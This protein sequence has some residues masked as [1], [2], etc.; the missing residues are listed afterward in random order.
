MLNSILKEGDRVNSVALGN[1]T[2]TSAFLDLD[3]CYS[4]LFD[5]GEEL[6]FDQ[7][8]RHYNFLH[9]NPNNNIQTT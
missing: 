6:P 9:P 5:N 3:L 2:V 1:G 4:V 8:G 7:L